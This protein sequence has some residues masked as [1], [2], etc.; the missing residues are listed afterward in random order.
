GFVRHTLHQ[1]VGTNRALPLAGTFGKVVA[2]SREKSNHK[3]FRAQ[4]RKEGIQA[5]LSSISDNA[6]FVGQCVEGTGNQSFILEEKYH[7]A[8]GLFGREPLKQGAEQILGA[9]LPQTAL[10][11]PS[12]FL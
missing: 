3:S 9:L 6:A 8:D 1:L 12:S 11:V 4:I 7:L 10:L 2:E 5:V